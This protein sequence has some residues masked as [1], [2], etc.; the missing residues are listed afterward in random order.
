LVVLLGLF[1]CG[2]DAPPPAPIVVAEG[3]NPIASEWHCLAPFPSDV[4]LVEDAALPSGR[5][6]EVTPE[7]ALTTTMGATVD[8]WSPHPVDG[9]PKLPQ[10]VAAFPFD[11]DASQLVFHDDPA[12]S[13][14]ATST[15]LLI[16]AETNT[17]VLH[18]A[19]LDPRAMDVTD[20]ALII[21]PLV[22]L[23]DGARYVVAIQN[24]TVMS[25]DPIG[26]PAAF[27]AIRDGRAGGHEV[28]GPLAARYDAEIFPVLEAAGVTRSS[29]QLAWDFTVSTEE[30]SIGDMLAIR[31]DLIARLEA[32]PPAVTIGA[33]DTPADGPISRVIH[34]TMRVPLYLVDPEPGS[35]IDYDAMGVPQA[36]SDVEVP[37]DVVIPRSVDMR[38]MGAPPARAIIY[39]HGFFGTRAEVSSEW[40]GDTLEDLG[41]IAFG[42]D[43]WGF[44]D[45]DRNVV[46]ARLMGTPDEALLFI[47]RLHQGFAN[48]IALEYAIMGPL[49]QA[50]ELQTMGAPI[51]DP[52]TLYYYGNSNGHILGSTFVALSPH[53]ER[54]ALGVGGIGYSFMM[55]RAQPF[56]V[57]FFLLQM[58]IPSRVDDYLYAS[59]SQ[60]I[61]DRIDPAAYTQRLL[62]NTLQGSPASRRVMMF[63][64]PGDA[65]VPYLA[66]E[67]Q[68]RSLGIPM[69][70]PASR[71]VPELPAMDSPVDGSA[72]VQIDYNIPDPLPGTQ[73]VAAPMDTVVHEAIR[74][75]DV[76]HQMIDAFFQ[77]TG[78]AEN[79]CDG[80]C[81]PD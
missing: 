24:L 6:V 71:P 78:R 14:Q 33:I 75:E 27:A 28:L 17:P 63:Y 8:V 53:I 7:A 38:A 72:L 20:R 79:R 73:A 36:T 80:P 13:L 44:A 9:F 5:R 42:V 70:N 69:L 40:M 34:G 21:R 57:L 62:T 56:E 64:G 47:D 35:E 74:R 52:T 45:V 81:D 61:L 26:A 49:S 65:A 58:G 4:F 3:C 39:G 59:M 10:I 23:R 60:I 1:A 55:F 48:A 22:R 25:G 19:E 66:T 43:W 32:T 46:A 68:A 51:Y 37:F 30:G 29:L 2:D 16:D 31:S 77:P 41:A 15:T 50:P 54:A 11:V 18:F 67:I 12:P 76:V